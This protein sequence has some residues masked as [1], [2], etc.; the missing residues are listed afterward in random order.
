M[1]TNQGTGHAYRP[2]Q[3]APHSDREGARTDQ[4]LGGGVPG[5]PGQIC[6]GAP[7]RML[8]RCPKSGELDVYA[9]VLQ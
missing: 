1:A 9:A 8:S 6:R 7:L 4:I 3:Q 5:S 2:E